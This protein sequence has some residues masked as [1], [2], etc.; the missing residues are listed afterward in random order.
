M[1]IRKNDF[2]KRSKILAKYR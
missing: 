2:T 1:N